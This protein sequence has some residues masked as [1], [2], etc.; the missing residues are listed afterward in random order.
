MGVLYVREQGALIR[1][2]GERIIVEKTKNKIAEILLIDLTTVV[3]FGNVHMTNQATKLFM[4]NGIDVIYMTLQGRIRGK[5]SSG[6]NKNIFLRLAQYEKYQTERIHLAKIFVKGKLLNQ[7]EVVLR[8]EWCE[9]E[10]AKIF[11]EKIDQSIEKLENAKKMESLYGIEGSMAKAYFKIFG[12]GIH[13]MKFK[14]R[15]KRPGFDPINAMLNLGYS[16]LIGELVNYLEA[17]GFELGLGF[18]HE[19]HYGRISLACDL[20]EEFRAPLIDRL[21]VSIINNNRLKDE[22]FMI[23]E[24]GC[25]LKEDA[26]IKFLEYYEKQIEPKRN[27]LENQINLFRKSILEGAEYKPWKI[28]NITL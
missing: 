4:D 7:R 12:L 3:L 17:T 16:L 15:E 14:R 10:E 28:E 1:K 5:V 26:F 25:R 9:K 2:S 27:I 11:K 24:Y 21:I 20:V 22:D 18:L 19:I 13:K 6:F 8:S 23:M